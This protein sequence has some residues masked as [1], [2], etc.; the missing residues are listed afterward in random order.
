MTIITVVII[1][2]IIT[3]CADKIRRKKGVTPANRSPM[4]S[5]HCPEERT[6]PMV[7]LSAE[8]R[9]FFVLF[10]LSSRHLVYEAVRFLFVPCGG[11]GHLAKSLLFSHIP[12]VVLFRRLIFG[13]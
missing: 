11:E 4:T 6:W 9:R 13:Y 7:L 12:Q 3:M 5:R 10:F 1:L 8:S 2:M